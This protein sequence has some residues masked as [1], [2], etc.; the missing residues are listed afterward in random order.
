[1]TLQFLVTF[2]LPHV[3]KS[4]SDILGYSIPKDTVIIANL[5][6]VHQDTAYWDSPSE[7]KP[8]RF[9]TEDGKI[10]RKDAFVPF[11]IGISSQHF[12]IK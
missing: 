7:F 8:D 11:S 2:S 12:Y 6:T 9:L 4:D 3:A 1:M 5:Y 10:Q